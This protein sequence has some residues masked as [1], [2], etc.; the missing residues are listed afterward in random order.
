MDELNHMQAKL[1]ARLENRIY[2]LDVGEAKKSRL[3]AYVRF[4]VPRGF[5]PNL[6]E[7]AKFSR[8]EIQRKKL[9]LRL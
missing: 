6:D 5:R 7:L 4:A 2:R 1:L 8:A 3:K 9:K